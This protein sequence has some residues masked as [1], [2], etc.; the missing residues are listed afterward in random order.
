[1]NRGSQQAVV[2]Q[3]TAPPSD[4][5]TGQPAPTVATPSS[6]PSDVEPTLAPIPAPGETF[7]HLRVEEPLPVAVDD[8]GGV[9]DALTAV[10]TLA[11]VIV[12]LGL[13]AWEVIRAKW[14][15]QGADDQRVIDQVASVVAFGKNFGNVWDVFV[16]NGS[17]RPIF[18]VVVSPPSGDPKQVG[19][20]M[21]HQRQEGPYRIGGD[22]QHT[23]LEVQF[24]DASGVRW[25]RLG[26]RGGDPA[27]VAYDDTIVER[28]HSPVRLTPRRERCLRR[29]R[30]H[31]G[32]ERPIW[33]VIDP[34]K[35][36]S[37]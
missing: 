19:V 29:L 7:T 35:P 14:A 22:Q 30:T 23:Q 31:L 8:G 11:A 24:T 1:M 16:F 17:D 4:P 2:D 18:N 21:P 3:S 27:Q 26:Q 32:Y 36:G 5:A 15:A 6:S 9:L 28:V 12:A 25:R 34:T 33:R 13:G 20:V 10:G 37:H